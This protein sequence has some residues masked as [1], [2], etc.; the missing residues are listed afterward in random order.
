[1][2]N[3]PDMSRFRERFSAEL[4]RY[5]NV[6][7]LADKA[8]VHRGTLYDWR[9]GRQEPSLAAIAAVAQE[10]G[11]TLDY[12]A[13]RV[14]E[15]T[16]YYVPSRGVTEAIARLDDAKRI[17]QGDEPSSSAVADRGS[18]RAARTSADDVREA[19]DVLDS[20][21]QPDVEATPPGPMARRGRAQ[22]G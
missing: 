17:L 16:G 13:G 18:L 15:R 12:L 5:G 19:G 9:N 1:M 8:G 14:D 7:R 20:A 22:A 4:D 2:P 10:L 11:C 3:T 6:S 21:L